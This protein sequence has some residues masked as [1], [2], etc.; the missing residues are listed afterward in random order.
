M[1]ASAPKP[2]VFFVHGV[3]GKPSLLSP[4]RNALESAG[5]RTHAPALPGRDPTDEAV[6]ARTG[7]AD[8]FEVVLEAYDRI[9]GAPIVIGHSLGGLLAQKIAAART[10]TAAVLLASVPPGVLWPQ[11]R[12]TPHLFPVLPAVTAGKPFL[13]SPKTMREVPL[14]TLPPTEQSALVGELVRDSGRVFREM[15]LGASST[16]VKAADV[17]CP[18]LCVSAGQDRNVAQ[19]LSRRIAKRYG[20]EHQ[21]HPTLPHWIIAESAVEQVAPPVLRWLDTLLADPPR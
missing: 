5:Y 6:L 1:A 7:I 9:G 21:V 14:S 16:R 10:P 11:P 17:T 2:P 18:V 12:A 4:W 20:A 19:W 8:C 15:S 3:F 13:P